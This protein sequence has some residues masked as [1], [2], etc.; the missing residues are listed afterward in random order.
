MKNFLM[1][2][3][4]LVGCKTSQGLFTMTVTN[5]ENKSENYAVEHPKGD[6]EVKI[7]EIHG[8]VTELHYSDGEVFYIMDK[9][10]SYN[11]NGQ[12][13]ISAGLSNN[14]VIFNNDTL[15]FEGNDVDGLSWKEVRFPDIIV[16]YKNVSDIRSIE[17]DSAIY[18]LKRIDR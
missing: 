4:I 10:S 17:F 5:G 13:F 2:I 15:I 8:L 7:S 11:P 1:L 14:S 12:N 9:H 18:T 6:Y 16:G 3:L